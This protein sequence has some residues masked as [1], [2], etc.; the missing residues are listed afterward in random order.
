MTVNNYINLYTDY[1]I[2]STSL[3]TSTGLSEI[4]DGEISHDKLT[5]LLSNYDY[6]S[7]TL[8]QYVKPMVEEIISSEDVVVLAID[9]SIEEKQY[10]KSNDLI[11]WHYD[12]SKGRMLKGV[13]FLSALINTKEMV[14]PVSV[15]LIKKDKEVLNP[16][17]GKKQRKSSVTKNELFQNMINICDRNFSFDYV[18]ADSWFSSAK[19]MNHVKKLDHQFIMALKTNRLVQVIDET[20]TEKSKWI[21]IKSLHLEQGAALKVR[22]KGVTFPLLLI[23][24]VF[25]NGDD[26]IGELYLVCSDLNLDFERITTLYKKRWCVEEY[27]KSIKNNSS[28]GKSPTKKVKT[29]SNHFYLSIIAFVKLERLKVRH[30]SNHFALKNKIYI[31]A[32]KIAMSELQE[33]STIKMKNVA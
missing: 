32:L 8:W 11:C 20:W 22:L 13:N 5:R 7:K 9:D 29:Q 30:S 4:L 21:G 33:L 1:L 27:H 23:K 14:L 18:T 26:T 6:D 25:K 10:T 17:T 24:Q 28:F 16:K 15:K 12:H 19:N 2:S 3:V 31:K